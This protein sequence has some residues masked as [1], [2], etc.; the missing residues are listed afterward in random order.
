M[1]WDFHHTKTYRWWPTFTLIN[2]T[3]IIII[4]KFTVN[5]CRCMLG[6]LDSLHGP[7]LEGI[8]SGC[9]CQFTRSRRRSRRS[10][11]GWLTRARCWLGSGLFDM[12]YEILMTK[13]T[14]RRIHFSH[15]YIDTHVRCWRRGR[16]FGWRSRGT[17]CWLWEV[18]IVKRGDVC[19]YIS[20]K[21]DEKIDSVSF[22]KMC[23]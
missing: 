11:F 16:Y 23:S 19:V 20:E 13:C 12:W 14:S 17:W 9:F 15:T 22:F 3:D 2:N 10:L 4:L 6:S 5:K 1:V 18:V 8:P 21:W 7:R